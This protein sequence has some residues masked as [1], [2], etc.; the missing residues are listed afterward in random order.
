VLL[1]LCSS[2]A[3]AVN[4]SP[5]CTG[6]KK[7]MEVSNAT[8]KTLRL[9]QANANALSAKEKAMPP[10]TMPSPFI[11]LGQ[12]KKRVKLVILFCNIGIA[13]TENNFF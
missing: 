11:N 2:L 9:L 3:S 12:R 6:F 13:A 8:D 5:T 1:P 10:C 4:T 7:F